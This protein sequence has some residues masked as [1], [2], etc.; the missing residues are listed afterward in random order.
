MTDRARKLPKGALPAL[1][2]L[3]PIFPGQVYDFHCTWD[4][5][6][7]ALDASSQTEGL[8]ALVPEAIDTDHLQLMADAGDLIAT[9]A[10]VVGRSTNGGTVRLRALMRLRLSTLVLPPDLPS[11]VGEPFDDDDNPALV[12]TADEVRHLMR[13]QLSDEGRDAPLDLW[14]ARPGVL[15]DLVAPLLFQVR[16]TELRRVF[17]SPTDIRLDIERAELLDRRRLRAAARRDLAGAPV[18]TTTA[19]DLGEQLVQ[20]IRLRFATMKVDPDLRRAI[21]HRVRGCASDTETARR[22]L[23]YIDALPLGKHQRPASSIARARRKLIAELGAVDQVGQWALDRVPLLTGSGQKNGGGLGRPLLLVGPPGVGKTRRA[24]VMAR[25]L[26]LPSYTISGGGLSDAL[27]IRGT[28]PLFTRAQPGMIISALIETGVMNPVIIIDEIDKLSGGG[29]HGRAADALLHVLEPERARA[30][31]DD[32]I[33][34]PLDLSR[35]L[36]VATANNLDAVPRTLRDRFEVV[37]VEPYSADQ[38]RHIASRVVIPGLRQ[39]YGLDRGAL[40]IPTATLDNLIE[41]HARDAGLRPL[42]NDL[43]AIF[44]RGKPRAAAGRAVR[45]TPADLDALLGRGQVEDPDRCVICGVDILEASEHTRL[46]A[47]DLPLADTGATFPVAIHAGCLHRPTSYFLANANEIIARIAADA[48]VWGW[49][50]RPPDSTAPG[51]D[52]ALSPRR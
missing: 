44:I 21:E 49:M 19:S 23:H 39:E 33:E 17:E 42:I 36:F 46:M 50:L 24:E 10:Q 35:V 25:A 8:I 6:H 27:S 30:F 45:I 34:F 31:R 47:S 3:D 48:V 37:D 41:R 9:A 52:S 18:A 40:S 7:A 22:D 2:V 4:W 16:S 1:I 20:R 51:S 14:I 26:G 15:A 29:H 43:R 13:A 5:E 32:F 38:R 11:A 12:E 28:R